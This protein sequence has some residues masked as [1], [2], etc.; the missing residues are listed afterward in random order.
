MTNHL[1]P[2]VVKALTWT[3]SERESHIKSDKWIGYERAKEALDR[4]T[5]L[6]EYPR[7]LRMP[8]LL[9]VGDPGNGKST[10]MEHFEERYPIIIAPNGRAIVPVVNIIMPS[11]PDEARFWSEI[12]TKFK[13]A[14]RVSERAKVLKAESY[15]AIID[16]QTRIL[17]IDEF[18]NCLY[19]SAK[20]QRHFLA[21]LKNL[22]NDLKLPIVCAGTRES[23]LVMHT[24]RQMSSR[25]DAFG[26]PTWK[27]DKPFLQL[28]AS[29][30]KLLPLAKPSGIATRDMAVKLHSISKGNLGE[31][32]LLI[33]RA[34][35]A[36]IR[37]GSECITLKNIN[38]AKRI[39]VAE[40]EAE[41]L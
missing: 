8:S 13:I 15:D 31:L 14:H 9:L 29:F 20:Q 26:L 3:T 35:T 33:K 2:D 12:L 39:T 30:E 25:F 27:L 19:G 21:V 7:T 10:I 37:D 23:I 4:M 32:V 40:L 18:H 6:L 41:R 24:D 38:A 16:S 28:L 5:E 1:H 36:A 11:L 34:A 22:S 17:L